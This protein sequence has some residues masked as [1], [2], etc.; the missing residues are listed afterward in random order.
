[1][2]N[3]QIEVPQH[4]RDEW[5]EITLNHR[6]LLQNKYTSEVFLFR[7][8]SKVHEHKNIAQLIE[9]SIY[10]FPKSPKIIILNNQEGELFILQ[11]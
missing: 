11:Q 9:R 8:L 6:K 10:S 1:M 3:H 7:V 4:I 5:Q 2:G